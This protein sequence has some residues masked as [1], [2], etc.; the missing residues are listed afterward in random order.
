[1]LKGTHEER[2]GALLRRIKSAGQTSKAGGFGFVTGADG[3]AKRR[4]MTVVARLDDA[5]RVSDDIRR[6]IA[7]KVD[8]VEVAAHTPED[9]RALAEALSG[10]DIPYGVYI[11]ASD[12]VDAAA[13]AAIAGLDWVHITADAPAR[14]LVDVEKG[15]GP[16]RLVGVSPDMPPGRLA[17]I[18][19][20]KADLIV[21]DRTAASG[22]FNI[23]LLLALR[24]IQ[25]V[26]RGPLLAGTSLG[27]LPDD[28]QV[29]HDNDIAGVLVTGGPATVEAFI[30]AI[31]RL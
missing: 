24:A 7:A 10:A 16:T 23:D 11:A 5:E 27:L 13:L 29:L 20:L 22:P 21:V 2:E 12:G 15:K 30:E 6:L 26:T 9:V 8:G 4:A 1:M 28:I 25:G 14:L 31:E 18:A 3:G 17:G 19:G